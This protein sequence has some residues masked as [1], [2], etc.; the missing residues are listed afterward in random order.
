LKRNIS[1]SRSCT[2]GTGLNILSN[3]DI[4]MLHLG[5]LEVLEKTGLKVES[6]DA[7]KIYESGGANVNY[8]KEIVKIPSYLVEE[9]IASAPK[10]VLLAGKDPKYD[11]VLEK[12]RIY[13]TPFGVAVDVIDPYTGEIRPGTKKDV[14]DCARLVDYIDEY[15]YL[16]DTIAARDVD[17]RVGT[18]HNFEAAFTNTNKCC[19]ASPENTI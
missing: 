17:Q 16:Y 9:A 14:A 1:A 19:L 13:F 3:Y 4:E 5:T 15:D 6:P 12:E 2:I 18:L 8:D 7:L 11:V 10:S